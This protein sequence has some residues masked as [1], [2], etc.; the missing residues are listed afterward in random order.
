ME[1]LTVRLIATLAANRIMTWHEEHAWRYLRE[2]LPSAP[3]GFLQ[4]IAD[5]VQWALS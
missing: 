3:E 1:T 2:M 4:Q 5:R